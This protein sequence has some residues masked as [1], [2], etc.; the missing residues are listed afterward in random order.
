[1]SSEEKRMTKQELIDFGV[2]IGW[3]TLEK[4]E[5][6]KNQFPEIVRCKDCIYAEQTMF[7]NEYCCY[8][9][10]ENESGCKRR[11]EGDWFCAGGHPKGW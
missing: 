6:L 2:S 10:E 5:E 1:M 3:L 8:F 11:H 7:V 9:D 4:A